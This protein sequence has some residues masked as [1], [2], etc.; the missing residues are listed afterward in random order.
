MKKFALLGAFALA[1]CGGEAAEEPMAEEEMAMEAEAPAVAL[2]AD[3]GPITGTFENTSADGTVTT[4]VVMEDGTYT[5]TNAEGEEASG[6]WTSD[7]PNR[8]CDTMNEVTTC[9][10]ETVDEN[11]VWT[12]VAEDNPESVSTLVRVE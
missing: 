11:G 2:A 5:V 3:G 6:T 12:S 1:A 9:Y 4:M 7:G 8:F 10:N